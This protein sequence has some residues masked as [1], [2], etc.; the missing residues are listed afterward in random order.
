MSPLPINTSFIPGLCTPAKTGK[1]NGFGGTNRGIENGL[2]A[3]E[4][5]VENT[6]TSG[7]VKMEICDSY[8]LPKGIT[9]LLRRKEQNLMFCA[10]PKE[11]CPLKK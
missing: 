6:G 2:I 1:R 7:R 3:K 11:G 5:S 9:C 8:V 4:E 10:G